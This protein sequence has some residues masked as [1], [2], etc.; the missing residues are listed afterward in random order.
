MKKTLRLLLLLTAV[1][2][3]SGCTGASPA[4]TPEPSGDAPSMPPPGILPILMMVEDTLYQ[5]DVGVLDSS[6]KIEDSQIL[7]HIA[8]SYA[9]TVPT[10][11]GEACGVPEGTPYA[12]CPLPEYPEGMVAFMGRQWWIF[13]PEHQVS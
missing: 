8:T 10:Q 9:N 2:L 7:G 12:R 3:A 5:H 13:L 6:N 4:I 11:N 1:L